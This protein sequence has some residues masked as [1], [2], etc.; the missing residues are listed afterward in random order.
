MDIASLRLHLKD[1]F[2]YQDT[3]KEIFLKEIE[4]IFEANKNSGDTELL[5]YKGACAGKRCENCGMKGYRFVGN[6]SKNYIDLLFE[7]VG[8]DIKDIFSCS[9]FKPDVEIDGLGSRAT[10]YFNED[11]RIS[12]IRTPD[13]WFKVYSASAAYNEIITKP[14]RRIN[15]EELSYW[16]D[17]HSITDELIGSFDIFTSQMRWTPFSMLY[18]ELKKIRTYI[19][20]YNEFLQA[21]YFI[22]Q[23]KTEHE[24]IDWML[25]NEALYEAATFDL[26]YSLVKEGEFYI[27]ERPNHIIFYGEEF[28]QTFS[29]IYFYK[30]NYDNLLQKYN[31]YT[32]KEES[33]LYNNHKSG[34]DDIF[35]L[36]FHLEKR[37]AMDAE[38]INLAFYI[39]QE[40]MPF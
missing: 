5:I 11:D 17:K 4:A 18:D 26:K 15:F 20:Y 32:A 21:N 8:D 7:I 33:K 38:G 1:E 3:T 16:V 29:F 39:N 31:T 6:H 14:P 36:R 34:D 40:E 9:Y 13:Y 30:E 10:I 27:L 12:F 19:S 24:L 28:D 35:S 2:T 37:K 25:A 23:I 22:S